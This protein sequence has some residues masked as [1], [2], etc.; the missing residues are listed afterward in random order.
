MAAERNTPGHS[1]APQPRTSLWALASIACSVSLVC[2]IASLL[3]PLLGL[4]A[5]FE[6]R[7]NPLR[8]GRRLALAGITIG[9]LG[10]LGWLM[11][12]GWWHVNVRTPMLSG[13]SRPLEA[14]LDGDVAAFKAAFHGA[15]V[16]ADDA[17]ARA[18]L[19][20][21]R[22]RYGRLLGSAQSPGSGGPATTDRARMTI[23]YTLRFEKGP[24]E[25]QAQ[26]IL[27]AD[28][29]PGLVLRFGWL[30]LHDDELGDLVYPASADVGPAEKAET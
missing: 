15:G 12:A 2:P 6:I 17:E 18:F 13:P 9:L 7:S 28:D 23:S 30:I 8:R 26:F 10:T 11:A 4:R 29:A 3:G 19:E 21:T 27:R 16:S 20:E 25:A 1:A 24:V 14:G 22:R 5:L